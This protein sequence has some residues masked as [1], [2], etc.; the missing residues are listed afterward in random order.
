M[1]KI[2]NINKHSDKEEYK[3]T[4]DFYNKNGGSSWYKKIIGKLNELKEVNNKILQEYNIYFAEDW[5]IK[6]II[7]GNILEEFEKVIKNFTIL[8]KPIQT[9]QIIERRN[10]VVLCIFFTLWKKQCYYLNCEIF[11]IDSNIFSE[12]IYKKG[13]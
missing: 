4:V 8:D 3:E 13:Y 6:K 12:Y 5:V 10:N 7:S 2:E 1:D 9:Y 11:L